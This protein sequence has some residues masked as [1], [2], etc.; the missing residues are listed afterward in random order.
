MHLRAWDNVLQ[1][2]NNMQ[3]QVGCDIEGG[4]MNK[5]QTLSDKR[6]FDEDLDMIPTHDV[7][8]FIKK[9][10]ENSKTKEISF[11]DGKRWIK[12]SEEEIDEEAGKELTENEK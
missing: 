3:A 9:I 11:K 6:I 1:L 2:P 5:Q 12:I 8:E 10:K 7:K 4:Q